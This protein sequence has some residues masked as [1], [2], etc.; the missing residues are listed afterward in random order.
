MSDKEININIKTAVDASGANQATEAMNKVKEAA[1]AVGESTDAVQTATDAEQENTQ[2]T[3]K[4]T[5]AKET[6]TGTK[7]KRKKATDDETKAATDNKQATDAAAQAVDKD[8]KER[9]EN[10]KA[11]E[12]QGNAIEQTG[13]KGEQAGKKIAAGSRQ[14]TAAVK[15]MGGGALQAAYFFDDLQYGIK[16]VM[17]NIPSLVMGFGGSMGLAGALS[18]ATLAGAKLYEWLGKSD[19]KAKEFAEREKEILQNLREEVDKMRISDDNAATLQR[20]LDLSRQIAEARHAEASSLE[21]AYQYRKRLIDLEN[22]IEDDK[23]TIERLKIEEDFANGK[24]GTGNEAEIKRRRALEGVD[25]DSNARR[26]A[27]REELAQ[28]DVADAG[29]KKVYASREEREAKKTLHDNTDED[30]MSLDDRKKKEDELIKKTKELNESILS[31]LT[32]ARDQEIEKGSL[33]Y[34]RLGDKDIDDDVKRWMKGEKMSNKLVSDL[35]DKYKSVD[36]EERKLHN[37]NLEDEINT[38]D[39]S[40]EDKGYN[41]GD[42]TSGE[43]GYSDAYKAY[44]DT[45]DKLKENYEKS[46]ESL[47][48]AQ[49][50]EEEATLKLAEVKQKNAS[51]YAVDKQRIKTAEAQDRRQINDEDNKAQELVKRRMKAEAEKKARESERKK[52]KEEDVVLKTLIDGIL[53][54]TG[55]STPQQALAVKKAVDAVKPVAKAALENDGV[56]DTTEMAEII[57]QLVAKLNENGIVMNQAVSNLSAQF[58]QALSSVEQN[59]AEIKKWANTTARQKRPGSPG[60]VPFR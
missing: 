19:E 29:I 15:N 20:E 36:M 30:I 44:R 47:I 24:L 57:K 16:G 58:M 21:Y 22:G 50:A 45:V 49:N 11:V 27:A 38:S 37:S 23:A 9:Q 55:S 7:K 39:V 53:L 56:I 1:E 10:T 17:N 12:Q 40:L 26:R 6:S 48:K 4:N 13:Q 18:I 51:E 3:E 59:I 52:N 43:K 31:Q 34:K 14:G 28:V 60:N 32:Y 42:G 2:A 25:M 54:N 5:K 33:R 46:L 41:L 8:T 35:F